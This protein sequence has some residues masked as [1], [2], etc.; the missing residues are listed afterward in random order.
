MAGVSDWVGIEDPGDLY[1]TG[2]P[3][4]SMADVDGRR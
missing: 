3:E 4:I 1:M 2:E